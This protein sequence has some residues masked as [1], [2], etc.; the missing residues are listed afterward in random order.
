[1]QVRY[2]THFSSTQTRSGSLFV[3]LFN[4]IKLF[5]DRSILLEKQLWCYLTHSWENKRVHTFPKGIYPKMNVIARLEFELA[6][7]ASRV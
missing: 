4:G 3:C 2:S 7:Y 6:N 5:N 1:M